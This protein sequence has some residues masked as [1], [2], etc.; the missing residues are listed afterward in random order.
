VGR[1]RPRRRGGR[2]G[3]SCRRA[4]AQPNP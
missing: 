1:L 4:L 3:S 2:R